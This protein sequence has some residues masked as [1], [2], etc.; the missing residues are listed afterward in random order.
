MVVSMIYVNSVGDVASDGVSLCEVGSDGVVVSNS[1]LDVE[2]Y[3]R[4]AAEGLEESN[5]GVLEDGMAPGDLGALGGA[6]HSAGQ[7]VEALT[8]DRGHGGGQSAPA[9]LQACAERAQGVSDVVFDDRETSP[10]LYQSDPLGVR[11]PAAVL[12]IGNEE[13]STVV[14]AREEPG[15]AAGIRDAI[16]DGEELGLC[17]A[18]REFSLNMCMRAARQVQQGQMFKSRD[19]SEH[20]GRHSLG[21]EREC[22]RNFGR[23]NRIFFIEHLFR[24]MS[25]EA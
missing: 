15:L 2:I 3:R 12:G 21:E 25:C 16:C 8:M 17:R 1:G 9:A 5:D 23:V 24:K 14:L 10:S 18:P 4:L 19:F 11:E 6:F 20:I 22:L 13:S 7:R